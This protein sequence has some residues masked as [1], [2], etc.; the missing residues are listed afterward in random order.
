MNSAAYRPTV[1]ELQVF[2]ER[3][4]RLLSER[5]L[6]LDAAFHRERVAALLRRS[7]EAS[8][9]QLLDVPPTA[10][11]QEV[12]DGFNQV[13]SLV[14]PLNAPRLGLEGREA[15][16]EML[17]EQV[18]QAYLNL[19]DPGR[20]KAYDRGLSSEVWSAAASP[21]PD[22]RREEARGVAQ[23]Y[24]DRAL[25]LMSSDEYYQAIELLREA[26]RIDPRADIH[27]L[28]GKLQ[29]KNPRWL[30]MAEENLQQALELGSPDGELHAA[31]AEVKER[32]ASGE[33]R[34][35]D[36]GSG[37]VSLTARGGKR[38]AWDEVPDVEVLDPEEEMAR[39]PGR[40]RN[41]RG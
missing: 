34:R 31:L 9:Y 18:T 10:S 38:D 15:V 4:A 39:R 30:R 5:P 25:A 14:H 2:F 29:A 11:A 33:W 21:A 37:T 3:I 27:A 36:A 32:L 24:Y 41:G 17:F 20:R 7:G 40:P 16:L 1:E 19:S 35:R 13:A 22:Q 8:F 28:L 26:V 23:T 6:D 12:Y